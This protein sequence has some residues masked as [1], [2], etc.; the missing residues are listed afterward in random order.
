MGTE[1]IAALFDLPPRVGRDIEERLGRPGAGHAFADAL[2][3]VASEFETKVAIEN[4]ILPK[5]CPAVICGT[6]A[7]FCAL[8]YQRGG[9]GRVL[10]V[11]THAAPLIAGRAARRLLRA[12]R[13]A[14]ADE[15][16]MG[17]I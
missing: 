4:G 7:G 11:G 3:P 8:G 13:G 9:G 15:D 5:D 1:G 10:G 2:M 12:G 14:A 6:G 16:S 17:K